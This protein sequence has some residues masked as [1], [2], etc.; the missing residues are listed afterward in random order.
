MKNL[1]ERLPDDLKFKIRQMVFDDKHVIS[2][3]LL[4]HLNYHLIYMSYQPQLSDVEHM[5]N[6]WG[7]LHAL[8]IKDRVLIRDCKK[9]HDILLQLLQDPYEMRYEF[10]KLLDIFHHEVEPQMVRFLSEH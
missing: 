2:R 6:G 4:K 5:A 3:L 7:A 1:Y 9:C 10:Q 8:H